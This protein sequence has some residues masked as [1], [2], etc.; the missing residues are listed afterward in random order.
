MRKVIKRYTEIIFHDRHRPSLLLFCNRMNDEGFVSLHGSRERWTAEI[1]PPGHQSDESFLSQRIVTSHSPE[2]ES[3]TRTIPIDITGTD[4]SVASLASV[5][6]LLLLRFSFLMT[7]ETGLAFHCL[8]SRSFCM[9]LCIRFR[10][11]VIIS[12]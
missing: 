4:A 9:F 1:S 7:T 3:S 10:F 8:L 11:A 6:F 2:G 5:F 12:M